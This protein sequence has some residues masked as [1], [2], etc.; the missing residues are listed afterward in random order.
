VGPKPG[1]D[2]LEVRQKTGFGRE[3]TPDCPTVGQSPVDGWT[4]RLPEIKVCLVFKVGH[5]VVFSVINTINKTA[6]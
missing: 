1:L 5:R 4:D 3:S 2:V 6:F